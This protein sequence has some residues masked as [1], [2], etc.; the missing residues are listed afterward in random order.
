M[1]GRRAQV[2]IVALILTLSFTCATAQAAQGVLPERIEVFSNARMPVATD[3]PGL[4]VPVTVYD[5]D[6]PARAQAELSAGLPARETA[7]MVEAK[8]R[9][10]A[11]SETDKT[12]IRTSFEGL[13]KALAYGIDRYPAIVFDEGQAVVYGQSLKQALV[14]YRRWRNA[15]GSS[16]A[17]DRTYP[18]GAK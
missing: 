13:L 18:N 16:A 6:A 2:L 9:L 15:V 10:A 12:A 17:I 5:L 14:Y 4:T 8:R 1:K 11:L 7:A 3:V